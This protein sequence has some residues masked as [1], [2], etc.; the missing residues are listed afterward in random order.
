[1]QFRVPQMSCGGCLSTVTA[2]LLAVDS[3]ARIE[4]DLS[5]KRVSV[6][7]DVGRDRLDAAL[8]SAG[9]PPADTDNAED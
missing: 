1:M 2:A 4:A 3:T 6:E 9:Y 5:S 8:R 7:S